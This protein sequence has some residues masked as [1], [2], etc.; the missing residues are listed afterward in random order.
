MQLCPR[1]GEQDNNTQDQLQLHF[2]LFQDGW[3]IR[4]HATYFLILYKRRFKWGTGISA[5]SLECASE[6]QIF[7]LCLQKKHWADLE[8]GESGDQVCAW[9]WSPFYSLA[10]QI[11]MQNREVEKWQLR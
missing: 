7:L 5:L 4:G 9:I 10:Q 1:N 6:A 2:L 8:G 3:K 11:G